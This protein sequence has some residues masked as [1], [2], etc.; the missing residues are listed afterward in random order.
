MDTSFSPPVSAGEPL[1]AVVVLNHIESDLKKAWS[2]A[3]SL[4]PAVFPSA[5]P[6]RVLIKPNLCDIVSWE[7]GATTDPSWL[8]V[9]VPELRAIRRDVRISVIESDAI[10]A[11]KAFRSC[12]E[13]FDRL[14]FVRVAEE[15]G[16]ELVNLSKAATFDISLPSVPYP[17]T[18]PQ[19]FLEE[20]FFLSIANLKVH[21]Y[22]RMTAV[23]KNSL[24][25]LPQADISHFH[26]YLPF[27][28]SALHRL[29]P[30]D[31][32]VIDARI[33]LAGKGPIQGDRVPMGTLV[34]SNDALAAD[35]VACRLMLVSPA[36][37]PHVHTASR[38]LNRSFDGYLVCG[39]VR[40]REFP[41]DPGN[42]HSQ[43]LAKFANRRFH[44]ASEL[45]T[46]RWI[47][48]FLRFKRE[49]FVFLSGALRKLKRRVYGR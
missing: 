18:I 32:C 11:Y 4:H 14:G 10:G 24:G 30:P 27:L 47:D 29:C 28:I 37:V 3:R 35:L 9:V 22:E 49:P 34:F 21:P 26:P 6:P 23:L 43:I 41:F 38:D 25:L 15:L 13:T 19:L 16:I 8:R 5:L 7:T 20:F 36:A 31:L 46:N 40:P 2:A 33:G 44:R 42:V 45:F 39:E 48:R 12:D 17:V 1:P